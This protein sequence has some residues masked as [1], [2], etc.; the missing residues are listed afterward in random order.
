MPA[1]NVTFG[2]RVS[3]PQP[4]LVNLFGCEIGDDSMV[5]PFVEIQQGAVVGK[6]CRIQSHS[7]ICEAITIG[8]DVFVGHGVMF[9]NDRYPAASNPDGSRVQVGQWKMEATIV[10]S[11]AVI[12]SGATILPGVVIGEGAIVGAGAVVTKSVNDF[13][14]VV[15]NPAQVI[16]NTRK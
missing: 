6:R 10:K 2:D 7:F 3:I 8:D 5:G 11:R 14:V 15:G 1:K 4:T 13:D 12:G 9:T 16:R